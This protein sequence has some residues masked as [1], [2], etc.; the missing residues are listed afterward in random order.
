MYQKELVCANLMCFDL[1]AHWRKT[2]NV[3]DRQGRIF[4][5]APN[6]ECSWALNDIWLPHQRLEL[7]NDLIAAHVITSSTVPAAQFIGGAIAPALFDPKTL[8]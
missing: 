8:E 3:N 4:G 5:A 7:E 1:A 6:L 2:L